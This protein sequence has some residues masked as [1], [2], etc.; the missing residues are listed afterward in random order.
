MYKSWQ[1]VK[2]LT[3]LRKRPILWAIIS[4]IVYFSSVVAG[5]IIQKALG[6]KLQMGWGQQI[7][8]ILIVL[9]FASFFKRPKELLGLSIPKH[10][11]W[12][13]ISVLTALFIITFSVIAKTIGDAP[14]ELESVEYYIYEATMPGLGEELGLRG[15]VFGFLLYY[16]KQHNLSSKGVWILMVLQALPFGIL[17]ILQTSGVEAFLVF[18]YTSTAAIA[19]AWLRAKTDSIVPCIIA[20]NITNAFGGFFYYILMN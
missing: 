11:Q 17:H 9:I 14:A 15:L 6:L 19:L 2:A 20:H 8:S 10:N 13:L 7:A 12:L 4:F 5:S 1:G 3:I 16:A 18:T